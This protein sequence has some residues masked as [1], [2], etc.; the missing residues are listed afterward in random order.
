MNKSSRGLPTTSAIRRY[1]VLL[2][3]VPLGY[4]VHVSL[5][6]YLHDVFGVTPNL[7][8]AVIG[9]VTVA[10]GRLQAFWVGLIYGLVMEVMLPSITF[11]NLA[12]YAIT[13]L[14][15]SFAFADK[16]LKQLEMDRTMKRHPIIIPPLIRTVLCAMTNVFAYEVIQVLY[17]SI[18]GNTLTFGHIL[19]ALADVVLTGALTL[20]LALIVRPIIFGRR[21]QEPVLK[22]T[23]IVFSK[24]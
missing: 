4:L 19:R 13:S 8:Y 7:L 6:P 24:K 16:S 5:M 12:L 20:L 2:F 14:F 23:P 17:I 9:I 22:N 11:L 18:G 1:L 10:Y 3:L 15:T 21:K